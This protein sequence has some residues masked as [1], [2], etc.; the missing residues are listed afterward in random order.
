MRIKQL[1]VTRYGPMVPFSNADLGPF[2]LI[3][4]PNEYG[5]TLLID[6][7]VRMLFKKQLRKTYRRQFG[8]GRRNMN[9]VAENPEGFV[10]LESKG[11][12]RK[13]EADQTITDV[14]PFPVNPE[15]FR[16]VF[17]VRDSDLSLEGE[18]RY[19][20]RVTEKL[21]GLR[22]SEIEK[23]MR[24]I[25]KRG[26][27]RSASPD[28]AL[29]NSA[30]QGKIADK[31][32]EARGLV[33]EIR[34]LKE[35][36]VS[37][38]Y[39]E[40]EGEVMSIRERVAV[41][42]RQAELL[43]AAAETKRFRKARRALEDYQRMTRRLASLERLDS[44]QLK[45]WQ[46]AATRRET[47]ETDLVEEKKEAERVERAIRNGR[48]SA[49]AAEAK[50][51]GA[52]ER[53]D[54]INSELRPR[55]DDYQYERAEFRRAEP[56]FGT[57]RKGLY[58]AAGIAALALVGYI[59]RPSNV[60]AGISVAALAVWLFL[61]WKQLK[62]RMGEGRLRSK[63]DRL[64]ADIKHCGIEL[65]SVDEAMSTIG[66][67]EREVASLQRDAA[68]RRADLESLVKE[69]AR[70]DSR[71]AGKAEQIAELD[72]ELAGLQTAT[73]IGS[74]GEYQAALEKRM[75]L[76]ASA[77]AKRTILADML[78]TELEGEAAVADWETRIEAHLQ[79]AAQRDQVEFKEEE[80]K[81]VDAELESLDQRRREVQ[82][83]LLQGA[84]K[85]H[86]VEVK[87]RELGVLKSPPPCRT[88]QELDHVAALIEE[89]CGRI[90][91]EQRVAQRAIELCRQV[92]AEER[93]RVGD[94]FGAESPVTG[95][96]SAITG[97]R[98]VSVDYDAEKNHVYLTTADGR[99]VP[100]DYLSG[101]AY[102]QLYLA[103]RATIATRLL[104]EEKGFLILDDPFVKADEQRLASLM[105]MLRGLVEDGW[106]IL[107]F[108][109]KEEVAQALASD[110][111]DGRV[112]LVRVEAPDPAV[113][114]AATGEEIEPSRGGEDHPSPRQAGID[115]FS[116]GARAAGGADC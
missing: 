40:L 56:Q 103:I 80:L 13:L 39:D 111:R 64:E 26:R 96:M 102:D 12:E 31:V 38:K 33:A 17:V 81:R 32:A 113:H 24:A 89:F 94:L 3:H 73:Q 100:A 57:Y 9:R 53:L 52:Q 30:E 101:G 47:L 41:L 21:T 105:A 62:L 11:T 48:R 55:I 59:V 115:E 70:I 10:V 92:D 50:A 74:L 29:A 88:T 18:D 66:D 46:R 37:G 6:A 93:A 91:G 67:V 65:E 87:A 68:A 95:Y 108:S 34:A 35:E 27:L 16:N 19:Y 82:G 15:D 86:G 104:A 97:G 5:K 49:T 107:Y 44:D 43:R 23:L 106:Q 8:T 112:G 114:S 109:A 63:K 78:P 20:T 60:V 51:A 116:D 61:G 110:I 69:K 22:S 36:L 25:Q 42:A 85:L 14:F 79:A 45:Q 2:T 99:R 83:A 76:A 98:Y 54:R 77:D 28:S 4:G 84:R 58:A 1:H 75:K 72:G 90:E 71:V 7:L